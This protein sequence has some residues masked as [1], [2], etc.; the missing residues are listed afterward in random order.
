MK[1]ETSRSPCPVACTLDILG[2]KWT[3]LV[4]RDMFLGA[5]KYSDFMASPEGITTNILA[6]RL[7]RLEAEGLV[8]KNPYQ[9]NPVRFNYELT[10]KGQDLRPLMQAM[11]DWATKYKAEVIKKAING[12]K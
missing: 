8:G 12:K 4:V 5:S 9:D 6:D 3:M 2:D 7:K 1:T 11:I 10:S